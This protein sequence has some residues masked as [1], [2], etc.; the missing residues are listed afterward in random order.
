MFFP[1]AL[2]LEPN[3]VQVTPT[4]AKPVLP[5]SKIST[6]TVKMEWE[7]LDSLFI[8][9]LATLRFFWPTWM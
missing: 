5:F 4:L 7:R 6:V 3:P 2:G 1:N 9:V 8:K